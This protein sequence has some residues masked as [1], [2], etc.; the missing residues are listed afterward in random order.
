MIVKAEIINQPY[1]G[2]YEERIYDIPSSWNSPDWSWVKFTNGDFTEWCGEFRGYPRAV[3]ISAKYNIVLVLTS[4]YLFEVDCLTGELKQYD[5]DPQYQCLTVTPG[6]DFIIADN[7]SIEILGPTLKDK[8]LIKSPIEMDMIKFHNWNDD[9]LLI[10]CNEFLNWDNQV[11]LEFNGA[12][13]EI[14]V[15]DK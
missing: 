8:K 14:N 5:S 2:E 12:T 1:S 11:T 3:A 9:K 10:T 4:D 6:G 15:R 13:F 7:Y